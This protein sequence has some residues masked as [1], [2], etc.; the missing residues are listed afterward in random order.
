MCRGWGVGSTVRGG[1]FCAMHIHAA[2]M[3]VVTKGA[4]MDG[5]RPESPEAEWDDE[6]LDAFVRSEAFDQFLL[7]CFAEGVR[8]AVAEQHALGLPDSLPPEVR[9]ALAA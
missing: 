7:D 4:A 6:A 8:E 5:I 2:A 9:A 3:Q 1:V